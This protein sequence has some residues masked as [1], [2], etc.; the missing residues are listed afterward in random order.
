MNGVMN[1]SLDALSCLGFTVRPSTVTG[2]GSHLAAVLAGMKEA[3]IVLTKLDIVSISF[4]QL[5]T[6][7]YHTTIVKILCYQHAC[8]YKWMSDHLFAT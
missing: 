4:F 8:N 6:R 2:V 3:R 7:V 1:K 5:I